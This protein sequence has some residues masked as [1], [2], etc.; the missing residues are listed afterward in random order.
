M[1]KNRHAGS[2]SVVNTL[3]GPA[4]VKAPVTIPEPVINTPPPVAGTT[5]AT[6]ATPSSSSYMQ[7]A[8]GRLNE[9][10]EGGSP[11]LRAIQD[12][13]LQDL[14]ATQG[15]QQRVSGFEAAQGGLRPEAAATQ[16]AMGRAVAGS[17]LAGAQ[18][19]MAGAEMQQRV[20][21][22]Q[23]LAQLAPSMQNM[24]INQQNQVA[25]MV[26]QGLPATRSMLRWARN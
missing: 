7:N 16:Q 12:R 20:S 9:I 5:P 15:L 1:H 22:A 25:N 6:P 23:T 14:K 3:P 19:E 24:E 2:A 13:Q 21:A 10:M 4:Q 8:M 26:N 17:Q 11:A 18:A